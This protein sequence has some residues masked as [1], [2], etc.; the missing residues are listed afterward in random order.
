TLQ[1]INVQVKVYDS[2]DEAIL[3]KDVPGEDHHHSYNTIVIIRPK[4]R[5]DRYLPHKAIHFDKR[6]AIFQRVQVL[7]ADA[8]AM[9]RRTLWGEKGS[10]AQYFVRAGEGLFPRLPRYLWEVRDR[11][12]QRLYGFRFSVQDDVTIDYEQIPAIYH[13][14]TTIEKQ[15]RGQNVWSF[16]HEE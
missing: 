3:N 11:V 9:L 8:I 7:S 16:L 5:P 1:R 10:G 13:T 12:T 6:N 2:W 4:A 15:A 14:W